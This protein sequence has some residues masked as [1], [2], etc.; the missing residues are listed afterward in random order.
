MVD[1]LLEYM[2][3]NSLKKISSVTLAVGEATGIVPRFMME[4][5]PAAIDNTELSDTK[6]VIDFKRAVG[7]C[8]DCDTEYIVTDYHGKCPKCGSEDYDMENGYEFEI[9]EIVAE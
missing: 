2:K 6:L 1:S 8:R 5:W 9:T 7:Q 3:E 4:C